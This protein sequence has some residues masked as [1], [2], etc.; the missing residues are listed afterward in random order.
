MGYEGN[1]I[2]QGMSG[3]SN[4]T[5]EWEKALRAG[6]VE[7]FNDPILKH[8]NSNCLAVRKESGTRIEKNG[9]VLG[10]YAC[11]NAYSQWKTIEATGLGE[12]GIL[13]I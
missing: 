11:L 7:H 1:P 10:I 5:V 8:H 6:H 2:S 12:I 3:I 9:K 13:Y 4:A